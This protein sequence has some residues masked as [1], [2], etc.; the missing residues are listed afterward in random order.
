MKEKKKKTLDHE[1]LA[2]FELDCHCF[3]SLYD[4]CT[5]ICSLTTEQDL[6]IYQNKILSILLLRFCVPAINFLYNNFCTI[7]ISVWLWSLLN[8]CEFFFNKNGGSPCPCSVVIFKLNCDSCAK[9]K[10][11]LR[12]SKIFV[13]LLLVPDL[14]DK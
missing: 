6:M 8:P 2:F 3:Y 7:F 12:Q 9:E 10:I 13:K 5:L 14:I 11:W 4:L 1:I